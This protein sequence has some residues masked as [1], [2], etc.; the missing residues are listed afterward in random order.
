MTTRLGSVR[1]RQ[2]VVTGAREHESEEIDRGIE[3]TLQNV[4]ELVASSPEL[5]S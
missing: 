4:A 2:P 3:E 1:Q 5:R